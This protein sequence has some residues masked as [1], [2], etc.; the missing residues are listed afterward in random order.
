MKNFFEGAFILLIFIIMINM[1]ESKSE[2][3]Q[4]TSLT[5][6]IL[7]ASGDLAKRKTYPSFFQMYTEGLLPKSFHIVGISRSKLMVESIDP[8]L[9]KG[10][11]E[12]QKKKFFSHC[13][14]FDGGMNKEVY[15]KI[16]EK[17]G[18]VELA[19]KDRMFILALPPSAFYSSTKTLK[20]EGFLE[21]IGGWRRVVV[22]KPIGHDTSSSK[23]LI[24]QLSSV[25][26]EKQTYR[27]DHYLGK[28]VLQTLVR[29]RFENPILEA[30]WNKNHVKFVEISFQESIGIEGRAYFDE[31]GIV[32]D[33]VQNHLLQMFAL[34][35]MERPKD[36]SDPSSITDQKV[37]ALRS[38]SPFSQSLSVIGQY[39]S[40]HQEPNV[41]HDSTTETFFATVVTPNNERWRGVP[42]LLKASKALK[43]KL[44][45]IRLHF[46]SSENQNNDQQLVFRVQPNESIFFENFIV[47]QPGLFDRSSRV[48]LDFSYSNRFPSVVIPDAYAKLYF[49]VIQGNQ[50]NFIRDDELLSSWEIVTPLLDFYKQNKVKPVVYKFGSDG[51]EIMHLIEKN[52]TISFQEEIFS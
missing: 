30:L 9:Q 12:E 42:F 46:H 3:D 43:D 19:N 23:Q 45:E 16:K 14:F 7:G 31:T 22:E 4:E 52:S 6:M 15:S 50:F 49:D 32:R 41:P 51:P 11:T 44:V 38:I 35:A 24:E 36:I 27:I 48:N 20:E 13:S 10:T 37:A 25:L 29:T 1:V 5:I 17:L 39:D 21:E 47:K 2:N 18:Q 26:T 40:Y 33:V 8:F 28:E 34:V